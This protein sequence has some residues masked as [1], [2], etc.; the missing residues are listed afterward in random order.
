MMRQ[1]R[2]N[3]NQFSVLNW[4]AVPSGKR[5]VTSTTE[6]SDPCSTTSGTG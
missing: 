6:G 1:F 5:R 4:E 3:F 2:Q